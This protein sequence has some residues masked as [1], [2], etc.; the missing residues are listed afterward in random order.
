MQLHWLLKNSL[1]D[2]AGTFHLLLTLFF[3]KLQDLVNFQLYLPTALRRAWQGRRCHRHD[4]AHRGL[5]P[6]RTEDQ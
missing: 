6:H 4:T 3:I 1:E 2:N 5:A